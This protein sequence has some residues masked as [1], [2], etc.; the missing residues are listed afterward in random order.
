ME[1]AYKIIYEYLLTC[2]CTPKLSG[3][4]YLIDAINICL[5]IEYVNSFEKDIYFV[6]SQKYEKNLG[7]VKKAI[8]NAIDTAALNYNLND[9]TCVF[10][11]A[12]SIK[13]GS[14]PSAEFIAYSAQKIKYN[15]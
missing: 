1:D 6:I 11:M 3:F 7:A 10:N 5:D 8:K 2:G 14:I 15:P 9:E 4:K 12:S 13:S